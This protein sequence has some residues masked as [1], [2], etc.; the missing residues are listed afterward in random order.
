FQIFHRAL[1]GVGGLSDQLE[2]AWCKQLLGDKTMK[3][4]AFA[5]TLG[6]VLFSIMVTMGMLSASQAKKLAGGGGQGRGGGIQ[7]GDY[8]L[9]G[10]YTHK[11]LPIF[12]VHGKN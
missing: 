5:V 2:P 4:Q 8:T 9:T 1:S 3:K 6:V 10:P 12:L 11:N 7:A